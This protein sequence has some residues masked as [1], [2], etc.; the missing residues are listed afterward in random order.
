MIPY[1]PHTPK[2]IQE[3]LEA[4]GVKSAEDLFVS[5]PE[6][7]VK[8]YAYIRTLGEEGLK[9]VSGEAVLSANYLRRR[10]M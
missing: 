5:I 1:L 4:V 9:A 8:A 10:L 6:A 2:E 7:M 3:M